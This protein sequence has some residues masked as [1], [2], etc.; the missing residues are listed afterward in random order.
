MMKNNL[1]ALDRWLRV[2]LGAFVFSLG[3]WGPQTAWSWLGLILVA[4]GLFGHCPIYVMLGLSSCRRGKEP[5]DGTRR[6]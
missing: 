4:T 5:S 2:V 3:F 6:S 1:G